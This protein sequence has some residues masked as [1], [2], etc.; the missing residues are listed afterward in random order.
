MPKKF[1]YRGLSIEE[2]QKLPLDE[3]SKLINSRERRVIKRGFTPKHKKL[4]ERIKQAKES[5]SDKPIK[6]HL[7]DMVI[8]PEMVGL[9]FGIHNGK[10]FV[11]V[12]IAPEMVG[13]RLG[14]FAQTRKKVSHSA[15][16]IGAT[17]SSLYIPLK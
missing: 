4:L 8:I 11:T 14:E 9:K 1:S 7:R 16:G 15:P 2:L 10:E 17:R 5:G 3:F 12:D 13:H 6:T